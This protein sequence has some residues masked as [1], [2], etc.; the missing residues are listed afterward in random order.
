MRTF[1]ASLLV[2]LSTILVSVFNLT[3]LIGAFA[4]EQQSR[5]VEAV[6][7]TGNRRLRQEDILYYVQTRPGDPF[8]AEQ[9]QR[10]LVA[11]NQ[12]GFFD[13]T[14]SRVLTEEG[15]RGGVNVIFEVTELPIIRDIQFD[16]LKS[17]PESDVLKAFRENRVGVSKE[18][19]YDPV[20]VLAAVRVIKE[21]LAARGRPNATITPKTEEV[22]KTST[23]LTFE[24]NEGERVRVV[25]IDF[26]GNKVFSDGKL[27]DQM[28]YVKEAG[29][30]T[31]FKSEDILDRRKL[32]EDLRRVTFYMR[33]K[34]YLQAR[35]GEPK[36]EGLGE[37]TTGFFIPLPLLSST[38]QGLKVT[39]PVT[40]GRIYKL[41]ELKIEGNS[42]FS[43]QQIRGIIGLNKGDVADG[44]KI[45]KSLYENLKK[46]Y[47]AQGFIQY[48]ADVQ[49]TFHDNPQDPNE[50]VAD[51]NI[52][53]TEGKQFTLRRLE[54]QGNTFTRDNVM[55]REVIINEGDIYNQQALEFSIL[56][57]NQ[58]GFF[59]PIDKDKDVDFKQQEEEG[60][61]DVNVKV[62]ERGRQQISFNGGISGIGGSFFGLD[63]STNNL[64]GRGETLSVQLAAGNRQKSIQFSFTEPYFRNR[65]ITV[66]FSVFT[67]SQK[68][69]GEG[70]FL[71]QNPNALQGLI[72]QAT[73]NI[74]DF[75]STGEEN[76]FTQKSTGASIFASAPLSEF[77]R[78]RK[79]T[80]LSRIGLS[81]QLSQTSIEQPPVNTDVANPQN[82]IP[83]IYAQP[84][85]LTSRVTPTFVFDSREFRKDPTDPVNGKQISASLGFAG[86][87]GDVRTYSP[88]ISYSQYIPVRHKKSDRPEVFA[89]RLIA[90]HV[91]SF[92]TTSTIRNANSLAFVDGVPIFERFFLGD[93]FTLRGYNVRSISPIAPIDTFVTSQNVTIASNSTGTPVPIAGLPSSIANIG[94]FTGVSGAN[95]FRFGRSFTAVGADTQ[96]LG[97]FEYRVSLFGPVS[98]AAFAD[99]GSAFNLRKGADQFFSSAFLSDDQFA[100]LNGATLTQ[101]AVA[102]NPGLAT[103]P[104][105][106]LVIRDNRLVSIDEFANALRVGPLDPFTLLPPGFQQGFIRGQAQ[107]NTAVRLSESLF[108]KFT[109]FR[110]SMG[111]EFRF[112][113]PVINVPFRLIY[114]YNPNARNGVVQELP[115]V[116]FDEKKNVFRFSV[117]RTF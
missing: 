34:G 82:A 16:G 84:N 22:S 37:K 7:V 55:R 17:V 62:T 12:L 68:F 61:V 67:Y 52:S 95:S 83:V 26:E 20:K 109:D 13:K 89:F 3:P 45:G 94:A 101:I 42:I 58:L 93:E 103:A 14:K 31:R 107:T 32:E 105:G 65:P 4:Q 1:R 64:L 63:Y 75:L 50:G 24:V 108:S 114:A 35:T 100:A 91:S 110:S 21:L 59:D 102:A 18:A 90:G 39:V 25:E 111:V 66:G 96:L 74:Q 104:L 116:F 117:G 48:E 69:F 33:S 6:S 9:A 73:G 15:T 29:L 99:V 56:R 2:V 88:T 92:A 53:I 30:I 23:A 43:E 106:G 97:N 81:Y 38:D 72:G 79:F 71:S 87:G 44:E 5:L 28:K 51:F 70:T 80:Q 27:R 49:P 10:D 112:Q 40:E 60:Q 41:G 19:I 47:G 113:I 76:L 46:V 36:I 57:L 98:V 11:I 86:L 54:F 115:G 78:K 8:S 77:Y 85:I